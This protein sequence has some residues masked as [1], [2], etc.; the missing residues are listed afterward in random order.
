MKLVANPVLIWNVSAVI[1]HCIVILHGINAV[2]ITSKVKH[3]QELPDFKG[4][5]ID[6]DEV[7]EVPAA[8]EGQTVRYSIT[9]LRESSDF[10]GDWKEQLKPKI[11]GRFIIRYPTNSVTE[12]LSR[13]EMLAAIDVGL[14]SLIQVISQPYFTPLDF[15]RRTSRHLTT[16]AFVP[17]AGFAMQVYTEFQTLFAEGKKYSHLAAW[18]PKKFARNDH[19]NEMV[20]S[21]KDLEEGKLDEIFQ[22]LQ[23]TSR[24]TF[25]V[26]LQKSHTINPENTRLLQP[27][28]V[29]DAT[30]DLAFTA[31]LRFE[32]DCKDILSQHE[33]G[34][35][36][37]VRVQYEAILRHAVSKPKSPEAIHLYPLLDMRRHQLANINLDALARAIEITMPHSPPVAIYFHHGYHVKRMPRSKTQREIFKRIATTFRVE[38]QLT[39]GDSPDFVTSE[40]K[41][42]KA[43]K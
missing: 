17:A 19:E 35:F 23:D 39:R 1:V 36:N 16:G 13:P 42:V 38:K 6:P 24:I 37:I 20:I 41:I 5:A 10:A 8:S 12:V 9:Q 22:S 11:C 7:S 26:D 27:Y 32:D 34:I 29:K 14:T 40:V 21:R 33:T 31:S 2:V 15:E 30:F 43:A 4:L 28:L 25:W 18:P 3:I